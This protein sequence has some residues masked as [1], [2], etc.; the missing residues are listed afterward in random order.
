NDRS[1]G[2]NPTSRQ[3]G[4]LMAHDHQHAEERQAYY[5]DQLCTIGICGALGTVMIQLYALEALGSILNPKFH[6]AVLF[7]GMGLLV[8]VVM[9]AKAVW[10]ARFNQIDEH[11]DC[12]HD[13]C[14]EHSE[15]H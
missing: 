3:F 4:A 15:G 7:G 12:A 5:F 14:H 9:R 11:Q 1:A 6:E 13:H 8:L 10:F 2:M